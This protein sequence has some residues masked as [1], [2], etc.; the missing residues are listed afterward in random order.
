MNKSLKLLAWAAFLWTIPFQYG[1]TK[2]FQRGMEEMKEL[3]EA[4]DKKWQTHLRSS[5]R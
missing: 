4:I 1:Y 5:R 3:N 2:G